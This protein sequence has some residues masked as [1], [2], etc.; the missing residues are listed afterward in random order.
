MHLLIKFNQD[1]W[2]P[3][4]TR[5]YA[6]RD[7]PFYV[8]HNI[9][10]KRVLIESI[11]PNPFKRPLIVSI[12]SKKVDRFYEDEEGKPEVEKIIHS[13]VFRE[14][15]QISELAFIY[16]SQL[17][18]EVHRGVVCFPKFSDDY[19]WTGAIYKREDGRMIAYS[20]EKTGKRLISS[21]PEFKTLVR[22]MGITPPRIIKSIKVEK[23]ITTTKP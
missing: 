17:I 15:S 13:F 12:L 14:M 9:E 18:A 20:I 7:H 21:S 6:T 8:F 23:P 4:G 2:L 3:L 10:T 22:I 19:L 11:N 16:P 5:Q 1:Y